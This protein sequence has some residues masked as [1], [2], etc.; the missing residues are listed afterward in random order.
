MLHL[1]DQVI[2]F[3][4]HGQRPLRRDVQ[5]LFWVKKKKPKMICV[6]H[7][8][9]AVV[10]DPVRPSCNTNTAFT[11]IAFPCSRWCL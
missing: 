3:A 6:L 11:L 1:Q 4:L 5:A 2:Q 10:I 9:V 8:S 7:V